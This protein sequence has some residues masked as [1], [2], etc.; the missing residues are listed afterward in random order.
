MVAAEKRIATIRRRR[1]HIWWLV[2]EGTFR[3]SMAGGSPVGN[4]AACLLTSMLDAIA[5]CTWLQDWL[6]WPFYAA[7]PGV[8][9]RHAKGVARNVALALLVRWSADEL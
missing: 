7:E 3:R 9:I 1:C 6:R 5:C 4:L 8:C 2:G